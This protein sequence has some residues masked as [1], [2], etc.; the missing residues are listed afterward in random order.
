MQWHERCRFS[1]RLS[2]SRPIPSKGSW[3]ACSPLRTLWSIWL[4]RLVLSTAYATGKSDVFARR[5]RQ[6]P[7]RRKRALGWLLDAASFVT[8]RPRRLG[9][10]PPPASPSLSPL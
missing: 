5:P 6:Q 8:R 7:D 9:V 2:F 10:F 1:T 3:D 4:V